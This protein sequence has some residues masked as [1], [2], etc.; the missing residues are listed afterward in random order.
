M[1]APLTP[2]PPNDNPWAAPPPAPAAEVPGYPGGPRA[3]LRDAALVALVVTVLGVV[4]GLLWLWL[5]PRVPLISNGEAVFLKNT[6]SESAVGADGVFALLAAALGVLSGAAVYLFRRC[7][8]IPLVIALALGGVLASVLAWRLGVWLGPTAD[9]AAHAKEAG[10][11]VTFDA[12][13]KLGAKGMLLAW[14]LTAMLTHLCLTGLFTPRDPEP[15]PP[16]DWIPPGPT[17]R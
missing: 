16:Q 15:S 5:A 10:R 12:P 2:P 13:L 17:A 14:P 1:T 6:E 3:E 11:G 8:G 4:L 7:G 9:V